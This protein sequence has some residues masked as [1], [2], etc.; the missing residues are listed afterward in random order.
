M[1][2]SE[3]DGSKQKELS[4]KVIVRY[5][6]NPVVIERTIFEPM[7]N[8]ANTIRPGKWTDEQKRNKLADLHLW[9]KMLE[10][11]YKS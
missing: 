2:I 5:G 10:M 11:E 4:D 7:Y 8:P 6:V 9:Y 1:I 3:D